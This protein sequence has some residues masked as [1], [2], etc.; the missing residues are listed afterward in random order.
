MSRKKD[1]LVIK[2]NSPMEKAAKLME[3][4]QQKKILTDMITEIKS[5]L[6]EVMQGQDV[7]SLKTGQYTITR[8][9]RITPQIVD[10]E[11][12]KRSLD[13]H[14]IPYETKEVFDERMMPVFKTLVEEGREVPG[15]E[16]LQTEYVMVRLAK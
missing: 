10:F 15:L 12:L 5:D 16:G 7:I 8:A 13:L 2:N 4:E 14:D 6:L 9:K 3:L 1:P 11:S